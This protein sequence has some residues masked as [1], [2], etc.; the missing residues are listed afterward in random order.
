M[1]DDLWI[2]VPIGAGIRG[3]ATESFRIVSPVSS[4]IWLACFVCWLRRLYHLKQLRKKKY[5]EQV[6]QLFCCHSFMCT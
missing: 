6:K 4:K 5:F 3:H 2:A 1:L